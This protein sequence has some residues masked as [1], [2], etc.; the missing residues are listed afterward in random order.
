MWCASRFFCSFFLS[1]SHRKSLSL[2]S[3]EF[4]HEL[5]AVGFQDAGGDSATRVQGVGSQ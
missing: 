4:L 5:A 1:T 3:E 2:A